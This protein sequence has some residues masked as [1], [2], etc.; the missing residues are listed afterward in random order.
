[1]GTSKLM[2]ERLITAAN[3]NTDRTRF[4]STRFGNVIGSS[5]SVV[6]I[7][8]NQ[9]IEGLPVTIT[10]DEMTRF[11]MTKEAAAKLVLDSLGIMLGGEVFV[12]KMPVVNIKKLARALWELLHEEEVIDSD[13]LEFSDIGIKPGE[14]LEELMTGEEIRRS[15]ELESFFAVLPAFR[16]FFRQTEFSYDG[17]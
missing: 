1:M 12:T 10:H 5:G 7:F 9:L 13:S 17:G 14:K 3:Y 16:G 15:L 2:G 8:V 11:I 6:P 4:S